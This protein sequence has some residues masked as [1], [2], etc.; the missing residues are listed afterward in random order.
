MNQ[1]FKWKQ[2]VNGILICQIWPVV[3]IEFICSIETIGI[4]VTIRN[5]SR[6][7]EGPFILEIETVAIREANIWRIKTLYTFRPGHRPPI[8]RP[9]PAHHPLI[10]RA[11]PDYR[12]LHAHYFRWAETNN[13]GVLPVSVVKQVYLYWRNWRGADTQESSLSQMNIKD[14]NS[15]ASSYLHL[16]LKAQ[17]K[18]LKFKQIIGYTH[19]IQW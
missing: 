18:N 12:A 3:E 11:A 7:V 5:V 2:S 19:P 4:C 14:M 10:T 9:S 8:A 13:R 6:N 1:Y 16:F 17:G 15:A